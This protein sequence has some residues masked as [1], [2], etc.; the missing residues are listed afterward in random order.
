M[1]INQQSEGPARFEISRRGLI[2]AGLLA[3]AAA[4]VPFASPFA[5][6]AANLSAPSDF[7]AMSQ[8]LT[9]HPVR[10]ELVERAWLALIGREQDF[11]SRYAALSR[12]IAAADFKDMKDWSTFS[13]ALDEPTKSAAVAVISAWYLGVVGKVDD[14]G[15][16]GPDFI[17]YENALM[18]QPTIDATVIPTYSK[19][20]PG[21]WGEVPSTVSTD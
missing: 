6:D 3:S 9:G 18:W 16:N 13:A 2:R 19:L 1:S 17:T 10:T 11:G 8:L 15:E 14:E 4:V 20:G 21:W 7:A 5:A 12:A